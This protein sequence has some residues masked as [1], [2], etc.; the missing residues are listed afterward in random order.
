MTDTF[1]R[2]NSSDNAFVVQANHKLSL[3]VQF[4]ANYTWFHAL[5]FGQNETTFSRHQRPLNPFA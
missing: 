3:G 4:A 1:S 2:V 5:D